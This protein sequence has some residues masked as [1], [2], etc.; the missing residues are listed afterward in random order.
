MIHSF[1]TKIHRTMDHG[2]FKGP[3]DGPLR[4]LGFMTRSSLIF[5]QSGLRILCYLSLLGLYLLINSFLAKIHRTM[6]LGIFKGP[7]DGLLSILVSLTRSLH[8]FS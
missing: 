2:I 8:I 5:C 4:T 1:L 3:S 6:D 7:G